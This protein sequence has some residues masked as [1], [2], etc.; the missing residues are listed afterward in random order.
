MCASRRGCSA[1][2]THTTN[3]WL[4][5]PVNNMQQFQPVRQ[6]WVQTQSMQHY[7]ARKHRLAGKT[8]AAAAR[9]HTGQLQLRMLVAG[10]RHAFQLPRNQHVCR[11]SRN[12]HGDS[13]AAMT[14][15]TTPGLGVPHEKSKQQHPTTASSTLIRRGHHRMGRKVV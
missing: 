4:Q 13:C 9:A 7:T 12:A 8:G 15:T 1:Q 11:T 6:S 5:T 14:T 10:T 2:G 3:P